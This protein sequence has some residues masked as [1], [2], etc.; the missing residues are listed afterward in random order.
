MNVY[1]GW[2]IIGGSL[3]FYDRPGGANAVENRSDP[4]AAVWLA[5]HT[6]YWDGQLVFD[7]VHGH[8]IS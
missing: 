5:A 7:T 1:S 6:Q 3:D 2:D 8:L 4:E